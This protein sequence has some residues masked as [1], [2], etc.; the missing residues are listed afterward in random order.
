MAGQSQMQKDPLA[1]ISIFDHEAFLFYCV[2]FS[3]V[4]GVDALVAIVSKD[5]TIS[6]TQKVKVI[7]HIISTE[8]D[9]GVVESSWKHCLLYLF[10]SGAIPE[11]VFRR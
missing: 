7:E 9:L 4:L 1:D 8:A 5:R 3:E 10:L 11:E 6:Y 2:K